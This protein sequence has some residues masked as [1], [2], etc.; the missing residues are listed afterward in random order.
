MLFRVMNPH[1]RCLQA[2]VK[3][4]NDPKQEMPKSDNIAQEFIN[5]DMFQKSR[6]APPFVKG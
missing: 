2:K 5:T 4:Q 6:F 3:N 1:Q